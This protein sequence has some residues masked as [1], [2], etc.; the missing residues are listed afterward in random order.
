M[1]SHRP[2]RLTVGEDSFLWTMRWSHDRDGERVVH[3]IITFAVDGR[4]RGQPLLVRFL[5]RHAEYPAPTCVAL[6]GD[7][8]AALDRAREQGWTGQRSQW[9]LPAA[10]LE[11]PDLV[12]STPTRLREWADERPLYI[13]Y[14]QRPG[15]AAPL[16]A[17]LAVPPVPESVGGAELQWRDP[18]LFVLA[19]RY[20]DSPVVHALSVADLARA[21]RAAQRIAPGVGASVRGQPSTVHGPGTGQIPAHE[22]L[23]VDHWQGTPGAARYPGA[24]PRDAVW[25]IESA[26]GPRIEAYHHHPDDGPLW[27]WTTLREGS[28]VD[29]RFR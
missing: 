17:A 28:A 14:I 21:I 27:C 11:R 2:R 23:P 13:A 25:L 24:R 6:P 12:V 18:R 4:R 16:A 29:R 20:D 9:L 10:G 8:R 26:D 1:T 5:S 19:S 15:L 3:V 22:V 7:A